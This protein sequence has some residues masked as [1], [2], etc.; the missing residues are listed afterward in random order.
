MEVYIT[1]EIRK[2]ELESLIHQYSY[3]RYCE[4][5][6]LS[7][8]QS[9]RFLFDQLWQFSTRTEARSI[10]AYSPSGELLGVLFYRLS[11]W[12]TEHF[13]WNVV[14]IEA[15]I[16]GVLGYKQELEVADA[17][18][19]KFLV[20]CEALSVRFISVRVPSLNLPVTH[21]LERRGFCYIETCICNKYDL[22]RV[23]EFSKSPYRLRLIRQDDY[24]LMVRYSRGAFASHR[25]RADSHIDM[26]KADALYEKWI[27]TAFNDPNQEILVLDVDG[28]PAAFMIY[29]RS[30]LRQYFGL[31][32]AM[33]K[34]ALLDPQNR[35]GGLGTNFFITL[36][37]HHQEEGLDV[38]DS[39]LS[40]RN[41]ASL[42]LHIKLNF[43][44]VS[45]TLTFHKWLNQC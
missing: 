23:N 4:D 6:S 2:A 12:D 32:F 30:D 7:L 22:R 14:V 24:P 10:V 42:N 34:M 39:G 28:R 13:G 5:R 9:R 40:M 36:L 3:G 15:I 8:E 41:L 19:Q 20:A 38:V 1:P 35:N 37:H 26:D 29:Y 45:T 21:S 44:V 31:R 16:T 25:F 17:L 33:W 27:R 11:Q 18:V 43:R